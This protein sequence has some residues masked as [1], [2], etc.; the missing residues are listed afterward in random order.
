MSSYL[1]L[2]AHWISLDNATQRLELRASLIGFHL[3][4]KNHTGSNIAKIILQLL[5]RANVTLKVCAPY[6][7]YLPASL[8]PH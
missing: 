5:D 6:V 3:L 7:L 4:Q 1:A 2:T 8:T